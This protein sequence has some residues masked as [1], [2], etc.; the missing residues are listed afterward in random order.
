MGEGGLD[1][2]AGIQQCVLD[3][4]VQLGKG[5]LQGVCGDCW[6]GGGG[7]VGG[8]GWGGGGGLY[9]RQG[10]CVDAHMDTELSTFPT[11]SGFRFHSR[12]G[13]CRLSFHS[14]PI[15]GTFYG[16]FYG[17]F[18]GG[19]L[20]RPSIVAFYG[21]LLWGPSMGTFYGDLLWGTL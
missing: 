12:D 20:W 17:V 4:F 13:L 9:H 14:I 21:G 5:P 19:L 15:L 10:F 1:G 8:W 11:T 2:H 3:P 7:G 18:Y 16:V 6:V